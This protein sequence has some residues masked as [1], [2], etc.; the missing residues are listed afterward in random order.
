M[1]REKERHASYKAGRGTARRRKVQE[2]KG[3]HRYGWRGE[4]DE[5]T[6][7]ATPTPEGTSDSEKHEQCG[8]VC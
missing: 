7:P 8:G 4:E 5:A 2:E 1:K 6:P 3:S